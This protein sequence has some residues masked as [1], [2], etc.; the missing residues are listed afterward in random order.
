M[1]MIRKRREATTTYNKEHLQVRYGAVVHLGVLSIHG[2]LGHKFSVHDIRNFALLWIDHDNPRY[3]IRQRKQYS[4][5]RHHG[6]LICPVF[7]RLREANIGVKLGETPGGALS[8][9]TWPVVKV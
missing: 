5:R 3:Q 9:G 4:I 6:W 1:W 2:I 7:Q 8:P